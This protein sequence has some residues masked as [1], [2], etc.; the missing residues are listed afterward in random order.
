MAVKLELT[1]HEIVRVLAG[2]CSLLFPVKL[3]MKHHFVKLSAAR[4]CVIVDSKRDHRGRVTFLGEHI[5]CSFFLCGCLE[6]PDPGP[7]TT[8]SLAI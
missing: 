8:K 1:L 6:T 4:V 7:L 2:P 3:A 5:I